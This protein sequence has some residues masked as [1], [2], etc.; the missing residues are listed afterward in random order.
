MTAGQ[1]LL[2]VL[3][4]VMEICVVLALATWGVHAGPSS[5]A[6]VVL[7]VG[8]PVI[9]FGFWGAVDFRDAG[10]IAEPLRLAQELIVTS[11]AAVAWYAAGWEAP[12][13]ALATLSLLY[14]GLVYALGER[15]LQTDHAKR[16]TAQTGRVPP[17]DPRMSGSLRR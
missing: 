6:K 14:H 15:L 17:A 9:G 10:W 11:L 3:R 1:R 7:G 4:V 16:R 13:L 12:G 8:V 5:V 2:L